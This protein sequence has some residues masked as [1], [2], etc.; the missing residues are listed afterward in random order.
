MNQRIKTKW[1]K[2]LRS[3]KYKQGFNDLK[4]EDGKY[5]CLGVLTDLYC[6]A[7]GADFDKFNVEYSTLPPE[8]QEWASIEEEDDNSDNPV[9]EGAALSEYN[10]GG[11][12]VK[13][14]TFKGIATLIEKH[15]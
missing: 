5:C 10:D 7:T 13:P 12:T 3:G 1:I 8:V 15:L 6:K 9:I 11:G 2:A 14:K 4:T